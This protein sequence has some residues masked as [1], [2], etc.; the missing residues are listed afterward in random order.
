MKLTTITKRMEALVNESSHRSL[1]GTVAYRM[2]NN[3]IAT[4]ELIRPCYTSGSG[5]FTTNLDYTSDVI[6]LLTN[7]GLKYAD[8][9][10]APRGGK[11]GNWI[12]II[13]KINL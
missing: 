12:K 10:D 11:P 13:T 4:G 8:G 2:V 5:R 3:A 1:K 6:R 7:L 9:N